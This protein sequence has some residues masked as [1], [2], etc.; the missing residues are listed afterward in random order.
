MRGCHNAISITLMI[1]F[2]I[3]FL[4]AW[5][6]NEPTPLELWIALFTHMFYLFS[7]MAIRLGELSFV[8]PFTYTSIIIA[9]V[10]GMLIW[11]DKPEWTM[12]TG[13][14]LIMVSGIA[15]FQR[16]RRRQ[17]PATAS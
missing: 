2:I 17:R 10:L 11:N 1:A 15:I 9:I 16:E 5:N 3:L 8:S 4:M 14:G 6:T 12:L 7:I 13:A